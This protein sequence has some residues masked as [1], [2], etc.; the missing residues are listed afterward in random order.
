MNKI[1]RGGMMAAMT[2]SLLTSLT[3]SAQDIRPEFMVDGYDMKQSSY[4]S[5]EKPATR[6]VV[7]KARAGTI[8]PVD[9]PDNDP[10][11]VDIEIDA[12]GFFTGNIESLTVELEI[13][14]DFVGDISA[15][16]TAP[17]GIAQLVLF[18][19]I[20]RDP[21]D[22]NGYGSDLNGTYTFN[23]QA[24]T[25][26]WVAADINNG[27]D[28]PNG[29]YRT[30]TAGTDLSRFGGCTTR[31]N[32]AF[33]GLTPA[34]ANGIWT[35]NISD[36]DASITGQVL[37]VGLLADQG[38]KNIDTIF[39]SSFEVEYAPFQ[40]LPASD[41]LGDC[42]KAQFDFTGNGL[43]DY[44]TTWTSNGNFHIQTVTNTG[45]G[46][47]GTDSDFILAPTTLNP[48]ITSGGDFDGDG[49]TDILL[50]I[51]NDEVQGNSFL[52]RRS[53]RPNDLWLEITSSTVLDDA[54][55][56]DYDGD[57][58]DDLAWFL[59]PVNGIGDVRIL[60]VQS[61]NFVT[62]L[63]SLENGMREDFRTA[64]GF[65]HTGDSI[66]DI[67]LFKDDGLGFGNQIVKV[68]DGTDGSLILNS[69][70]GI[71]GIFTSEIRLLPGY[72]DNNGTAGIGTFSTNDFGPFNFITF[73]DSA[74]D[75]PILQQ[76]NFGNDSSDTPITGDY[77]GDGIDDFGVWRPDTDDGLGNRFII[78]PS[79][80]V[81]P[82][83]NLIEVSP[84]DAFSDDYPLGNVRVR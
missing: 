10:D 27:N 70:N 43:S 12:T 76:I 62:R 17:N 79:G 33:K 8:F 49:I 74:S 11:G 38:S 55:I 81:D 57:G 60:I 29:L 52:V 45:N 35:L 47:T 53:S 32:G 15:T 66:N 25:D 36:N 65:D 63:H 16:L 75:F 54:Q 42:K 14:H 3:L 28:I 67:V 78:R 13:E 46:T 64:A 7:T 24:T 50:R 73:D 34:Q 44:T 2:T 1:T 6:Q 58:L 18:S 23:D 77:D 39:K 68:F 26:F 61:T 48:V 83:N 5:T 9:I 69:N 40:L 37:S 56:G 31:L 21:N 59:S 41:V 22:I 71:S 82:D 51:D 20:G 84:N 80:S 4:K 19:R 72:F 30:S